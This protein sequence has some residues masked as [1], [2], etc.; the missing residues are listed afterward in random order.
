MTAFCHLKHFGYFSLTL[1][2]SNRRNEKAIPVNHYSL[3]CVFQSICSSYSRSSTLCA[4]ISF[5]HR[6]N[7][8]FS[9][10]NWTS[11][12]MHF[13]PFGK[14]WRLFVKREKNRIEKRK[15]INV[16]FLFFFH[17]FVHCRLCLFTCG[18]CTSKTDD[19]KIKTTMKSIGISVS[20]KRACGHWQEGLEYLGEM[21]VRCTKNQC[22]N[23]NTVQAIFF[24]TSCTS[25]SI[26]FKTLSSNSLAAQYGTYILHEGF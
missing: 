20:R 10:N 14:S 13:A 4:F 21:N 24:S 15:M 19:R 11:R 6:C 5:T 12:A 22:N 26:L 9:T 18:F 8:S 16:A 17:F 23:C 3:I 25:T 2:S 1:F 7:S